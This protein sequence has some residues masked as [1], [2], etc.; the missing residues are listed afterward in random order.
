MVKIIPTIFAKTKKEF[1]ERFFKIIKISKEIQIDFMDGHFVRN[2]GIKLSDVPNLKHFKNKFEAHLM[3]NHPNTWIKRLKNKGFHKVIFHYESLK[4]EN[5]IKKLVNEIHKL[6]M[7]A[8][9][10]INPDTHE[11]KILSVL[12]FIDG[13]LIMGVYPGKEHQK[14]IFKTYLKI[15]NIREKNK[16]IPI[17]VDGGVNFHNS[18]RLSEEGATILNSGSLIANSDNPKEVLEEL[19]FL[20]DLPK[21]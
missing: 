12:N 5:E 15:K 19:R 4:N 3:T 1:D 20:V 21:N 8:F 10:A 17:Q 9:I 13:I 11:S 14:L 16:K 2:K 18:R 6:D 7:E